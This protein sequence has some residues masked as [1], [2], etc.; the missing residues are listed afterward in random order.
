MPADEMGT[1]NND[2]IR[3]KWKKNCE[4]YS[5]P[6]ELEGERKDEGLKE[7]KGKKRERN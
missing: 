4:C 6:D 3:K 1:K 5:A 2:W 7:S